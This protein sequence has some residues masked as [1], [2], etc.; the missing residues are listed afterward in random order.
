VLAKNSAADYDTEWLSAGLPPEIGSGSVDFGLGLDSI[1]STTVLDGA[2]PNPVDARIVVFPAGTT[3]ATHDPEDYA[4]EGIAFFVGA[5][6]PGVSFDV[7][8][9]STS[10]THGEYEFY[11]QYER[12]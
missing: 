6:V 1:T 7:I 10:E 3:T 8:A 11:Y 9:S 4:L 12:L 2:T 5:V